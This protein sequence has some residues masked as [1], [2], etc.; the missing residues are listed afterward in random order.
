MDTQEFLRAYNESR[1]GTASYTRHSLTPRLV[2][3][4]GVKECAG[5]GMYWFL[6]IV[7]TEVVPLAMKTPNVGLIYITAKDSKA[8]IR[9]EFDDDIV[10]WSKH[11]D[12]TDLPSGKFTFAVQRNDN[13][14]VLILLS[15][16]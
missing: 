1:N 12:Y 3:S 2:Y 10:A 9:L 15:E 14:V 5:A 16:Y 7:G 8:H 11:I 13:N 4:D 6:D